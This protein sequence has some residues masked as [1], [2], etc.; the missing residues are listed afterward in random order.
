MN[1]FELNVSDDLKKKWN[2][3]NTEY[4]PVPNSPYDCKYLAAE[5]Q[6][7]FDLLGE[8]DTSYVDEEEI[9]YEAFEI[10][11]SLTVENLH[12]DQLSGH[13][14]DDAKM[15]VFTMRVVDVVRSFP[16]DS[17]ERKHLRSICVN[18]IDLLNLTAQELK[19]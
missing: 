14:K 8:E 11:N 12:K 18:Y 9:W 6:E 5:T 7:L 4:L 17:K 19:E 1:T 15:W 16:V 13:W 3:K 10:L 2:E